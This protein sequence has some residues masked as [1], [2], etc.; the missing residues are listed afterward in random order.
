MKDFLRSCS[1]G[2][3]DAF[4]RANESFFGKGQ[5]LDAMQDYQNA[6]RL[7][8]EKEDLRKECYLRLSACYHKAA[9]KDDCEKLFLELLILDPDTNINVGD[10]ETRENLETL[11]E[12]YLGEKQ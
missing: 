5:F 1:N 2:G 11:K 10:Q 8:L 4:C 12:K 7:G 3:F 9:R 6:M